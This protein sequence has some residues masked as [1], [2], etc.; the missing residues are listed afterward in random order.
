M[1]IARQ[2]ILHPLPE[3]ARQVEAIL[4]EL[5]AHY[6]TFP[7]YRLGFRYRPAGNLGEIGR[8]AVWDSPE[9]AN[10]ASQD[11][12]VVA[13]R[14]R[15]NNMLHGEHIERVLDIEGTPQNLPGG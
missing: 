12:H 9:A 15:L 14:A 5:E 3:E 6:A 8:I 13:L 4:D 2:S 7:G 1:S 11:N 10:H